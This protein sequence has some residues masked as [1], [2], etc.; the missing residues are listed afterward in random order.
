MLNLIFKIKCGHA[1]STTTF[2]ISNECFKWNE[3]VSGVIQVSGPNAL[4]KL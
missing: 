4:D 1:W 2:R 3:R